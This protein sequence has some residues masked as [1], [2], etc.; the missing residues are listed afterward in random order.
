MKLKLI[1]LKYPKPNLT[2][3]GST[4]TQIYQSLENFRAFQF[5]DTAVQN[6]IRIVSLS[7][8]NHQSNLER[9]KAPADRAQMKQFSIST[10]SCALGVV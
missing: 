1:I 2:R 8:R 5:S 4:W 3:H 7:S 9:P 6:W 10:K